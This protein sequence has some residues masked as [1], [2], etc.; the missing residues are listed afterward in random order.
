MRETTT[1][2]LICCRNPDIWAIAFEGETS[3]AS[4][5]DLMAYRRRAG[6]VQTVQLAQPAHARRRHIAEPL[7]IHSAS[8]ARRLPSA[9]MV[10]ELVGLQPDWPFFRTSSAAGN[11]SGS[12]SPGARHRHRLIVLD[13]PSP[14]STCRSGSDHHQLEHLQRTWA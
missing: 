8:R 10:L 3:P 2:K 13:E 9:G 6:G 1:S 5:Q 14:R 7:E 4:R 11:A 12:P